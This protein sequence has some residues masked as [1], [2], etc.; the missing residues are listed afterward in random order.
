MSMGLNTAGERSR[1][2]LLGKIL[3]LDLAHNFVS[4]IFF[5]SLITAG[6]V[7]TKSMLKK[8]AENKHTIIYISRIGNDYIRSLVSCGKYYQKF[9]YM[10]LLC[11]LC[12]KNIAWCMSICRLTS[13][14]HKLAICCAPYRNTKHTVISIKITLN[15]EKSAVQK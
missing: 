1:K 10:R 9:I 8:L 5:Q 2:T 6:T 3:V 4:E 13:I 14:H 15:S 7:L 12:M 11:W